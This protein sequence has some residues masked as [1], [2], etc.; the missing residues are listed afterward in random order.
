MNYQDL[1]THYFE[2]KHCITKTII[3]LYFMDINHYILCVHVRLVQAK[4]TFQPLR[5]THTPPGCVIQSLN[6]IVIVI[7]TAA[8]VTDCSK[9]LDSSKW[10]YGE[11]P[12]SRNTLNNHD[13]N[14]G[15]H[16]HSILTTLCAKTF[17][18]FRRRDSK[19]TCVQTTRFYKEKMHKFPW[20]RQLTFCSTHLTVQENTGPLSQATPLQ[21]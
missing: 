3:V 2:A 9:V 10:I 21:A 16:L 8:S 17:A 11:K 18:C 14:K 12:D 5:E 4:G 1:Q 6:L 20:S 13:V 15:L 19:R 7:Q